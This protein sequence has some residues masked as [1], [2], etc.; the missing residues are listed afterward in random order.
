MTVIG[1]FTHTYVGYDD[2]IGCGSL[3]RTDGLLHDTIGGKVFAADRI[4]DGREA[5]EHD[6]GNVERG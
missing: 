6:G 5:E 4:L 2:E 1:V 3:K